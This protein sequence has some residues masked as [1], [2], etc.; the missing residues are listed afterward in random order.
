M[1]KQIFYLLIF[2]SSVLLLTLD[3]S[4]S[5]DR[6]SKDEDILRFPSQINID[7]KLGAVKV[8]SGESVPFEATLSNVGDEFAELDEIAPTNEAFTVFL[9]EQSGK[10]L[11]G[12]LITPFVKTGGK[13]VNKD[14]IST[15]R[16]NPKQSKIVS[17]DLLNLL[18]A[19]PPGRYNVFAS[20]KSRGGV[21]I[22]SKELPLDVEQANITY[23]FSEWEYDRVIG[24][25]LKTVW[26]HRGAKYVLFY[27]ENNPNNPEVIESSKRVYESEKAHEAKISSVRDY[28]QKNLHLVWIDKGSFFALKI[29]DG[30]AVGKPKEIKLP[31]KAFRELGPSF[32]DKNGVLYLFFAIENAKKNFSIFAIKYQEQSPNP[33]RWKIADIKGSLVRYS[34]LVDS[35]AKL[36]FTAES[37]DENIYYFSYDLIGKQM[38]QELKNLGGIKG[39][40]VDL[41]FTSQFKT[42]KGRS[43]YYI[44]Y[45]TKI[46]GDPSGYT[47]YLLQLGEGEPKWYPKMSVFYPQPLQIIQGIIDLDLKPYYLLRSKD[48]KIFY[49]SYFS[50]DLDEVL[51]PENS[52]K[53]LCTYPKL[54]LSASISDKFGVYLRYIKDKE[55]FVYKFLEEIKR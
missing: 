46:K 55:S 27:T 43:D 35:E 52:P 48:N 34:L 22:R 38:S 6:Q 10:E 8:I 15:F 33:E 17:G 7:L 2:I 49:K 3:S 53:S 1:R 30:K 29:N 45:L 21:D 9:R 20:Y 32:T 36:N 26:G 13:V 41:I 51:P 23:A 18:G 40:I 19:I 28:M 24:S 12:T 5:K 25:N 50:S 11:K 44:Y 4:Q 14:D 54:V 31:Y 37:S 39:K 42:S 47:G 16:L